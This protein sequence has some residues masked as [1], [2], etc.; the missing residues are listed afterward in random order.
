MS[1]NKHIQDELRELNSTLPSHAKEPVFSVPES[2]FEN[3]AASVLVKLKEETAISAADELTSLSPLLAGLS[4]KMPYEVPQNYFTS[5]EETTPTLIQEDVLPSFLAVHEKTNPYTIPAG[6][7]EQLPDQVLAKVTKQPAKVVS[8]NRTRWMRVAA[9]AM[10]A[11]VMAIS[12]WVY[13][14]SRSSTDPVQSS[15]AWLASELKN[16]SNQDLETFIETTTMPA[17][18]QVASKSKVEVQKMLKDVSVKEI[19]AFLAQLPT[20]DELMILN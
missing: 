10:V 8:F 6:Y 20:D 5:L 3:F 19:D 18:Q 14:N 9:A 16:V 15:E 17:D 13:Y 1:T 12:G 11:G 4:K 7:F 2:Y